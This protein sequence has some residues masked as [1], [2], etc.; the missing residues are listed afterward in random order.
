MNITLL[1]F[2]E[3]GKIKRN[4]FLNLLDKIVFELKKIN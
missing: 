1:L 3:K 4:N 2:L